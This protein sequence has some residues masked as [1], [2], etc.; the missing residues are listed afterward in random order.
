MSNKYLESCAI[1]LHIVYSTSNWSVSTQGNIRRIFKQAHSIFQE[2]T[3]PK[4]Y[5]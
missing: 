1:G 4:V 5:F 3:E 2:I